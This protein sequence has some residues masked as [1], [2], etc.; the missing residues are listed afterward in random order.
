MGI[1]SPA[2]SNMLDFIHLKTQVVVTKAMS[3][4]ATTT[5]TTTTT[6]TTTA[7]ATT[8][9][10]VTTTTTTTTTTAPASTMTTGAK[11]ITDSV[12]NT[13]NIDSIDTTNDNVDTSNDNVDAT[14]YTDELA[15]STDSST[16]VSDDRRIQTNA[17]VPM[18]Q[19]P[20]HLVQIA[21]IPG[22]QL[23]AIFVHVGGKILVDKAKQ[24][25]NLYRI[26]RR[27]APNS[28]KYTFEKATE[29]PSPE[30]TIEEVGRVKD[31][32]VLDDVLEGIQV[33]CACE[34]GFNV[35]KEHVTNALMA[36]GALDLR[37]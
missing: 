23:K 2:I 20:K 34:A 33:D 9:T 8:A 10:T 14:D 17:N 28:D 4:H 7:T 1:Y 11:A 35:W 30:F 12:C 37:G 22:T 15:V 27:S 32:S 16:N 13:N 3:S 31:P 6:T 36:I 25:H 24:R 21:F 5:A 26:V 18:L 29:Q 19:A